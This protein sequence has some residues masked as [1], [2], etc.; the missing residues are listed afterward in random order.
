MTTFL[1]RLPKAKPAPLERIRC[2]IARHLFRKRLYGFKLCVFLVPRDHPW[3]V[4]VRSAYEDVSELT[5]TTLWPRDPRTGTP[6]VD[7]HLKHGRGIVRS[8]WVTPLV[9]WVTLDVLSA[10]IPGPIGPLTD[11]DDRIRVLQRLEEGFSAFLGA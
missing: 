7:R 9:V 1:A 11:L 3:S 8:I 2:A 5:D 10:R 6:S 4:V